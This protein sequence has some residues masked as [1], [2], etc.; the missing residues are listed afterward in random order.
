MLVN[1]HV[2]L[3][4]YCIIQNTIFV[5]IVSRHQIKQ[6][7]G[8]YSSKYGTL[9]HTY[10]QQIAHVH[11][12]GPYVGPSLALCPEHAYLGLLIELQQF[13]II[14]CPHSQLSLHCRDER[15]P[16]EESAL[17]ELNHSSQLIFRQTLVQTYNANVFLT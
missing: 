3:T 11:T 9:A 16:L 1:S 6:L 13:A 12:E 7:R 14:D 10:A 8:Y 15:G 4:T 17:Q 5:V 2:S